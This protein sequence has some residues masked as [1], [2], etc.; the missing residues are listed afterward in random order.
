MYIVP[1]L[2]PLQIHRHVEYRL[3]QVAEEFSVVPPAWFLCD[4]YKLNKQ[5]SNNKQL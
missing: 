1:I 2:V 3:L 5:L 4:Y